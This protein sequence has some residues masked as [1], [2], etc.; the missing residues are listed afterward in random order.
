MATSSTGEHCR[1]EPSPQTPGA[2]TE[3]F[4]LLLS[5]LGR[6]PRGTLVARHRICHILGR[7]LWALNIGPG[8]P[9]TDPHSIWAEDQP[10]ISPLEPSLCRYK[11]AV[12]LPPWPSTFLSGPRVSVEQKRAQQ[13]ATTTTPTHNE[14]NS[15]WPGLTCWTPGWVPETLQRV[16]PGTTVLGYDI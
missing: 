2:S 14:Q 10:E 5:E 15:Q 1:R 11:Q 13:G 6:R 16:N 4:V 8:G 7:G 12:S 9:S 3:L